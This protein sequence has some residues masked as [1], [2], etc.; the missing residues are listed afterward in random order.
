MR[1]TDGTGVDV[2]VVG[3]EVVGASCAYHLAARGLSVAVVTL[4]SYRGQHDQ[5]FASVSAWSPT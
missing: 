4:P 3:T 1:V 5:S 2:V